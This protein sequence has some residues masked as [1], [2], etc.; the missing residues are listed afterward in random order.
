VS[1]P[2]PVPAPT[3]HGQAN[4]R[5][6]FEIVSHEASAVPVIPSRA[7]ERLNDVGRKALERKLLASYG[8]EGRQDSHPL[9]PPRDGHDE[10][11]PSSEAI[12]AETGGL[13]VTVLATQ[14]E[15]SVRR[16]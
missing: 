6:S 11:D 4:V 12:A 10:E 3:K 5:V 16:L 8:L 13:L 15:H 9:E 1:L 14:E 2:P 7:R